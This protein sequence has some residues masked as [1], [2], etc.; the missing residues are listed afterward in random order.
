MTTINV[1]TAKS[2]NIEVGENITAAM[3]SPFLKNT[4]GIS[5]ILIISDDIVAPLYINIIKSIILECGIRTYDFIIKNGEQSK[6]TDNYLNIID[7]LSDNDFCRTDLIIALGGGV[8]GDLAGFCAGTYMRGIRFI[9]IPTTL[10]AII[11]SSVGG[12]TAVN[13]KKGK[14]LLGVF[15]QPDLVIADLTFLNSLPKPQ[16]QNGIGELIKYTLLSDTDLFEICEDGIEKNLKKIISQCI[17]FKRNIV[18]QDEKEFG[19]RALLN[20][21]HTL[22]H[23][24]E[25]ISNYSILHG[26]AVAMGIK[27]MIDKALNSGHITKEEYM[28]V[29]N[30]LDKAGLSTPCPYTL[31]KIL[32]NIKNDKKIKGDYITLVTIKKFKTCHLEKL[33]LADIKDFFNI[34]KD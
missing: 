19:V 8:V 18:I 22:G 3:L 23:A 30:L 10:L 32:E 14:N 1:N 12:K 9:Q 21:G 31:D 4:A 34:D 26:F 25:K 29:Y 20:L 27:F 6:N 28:R 5:K 17:I 33:K 15:Y 11:D 16:W 7:Y 24:I 2:Y 13:L